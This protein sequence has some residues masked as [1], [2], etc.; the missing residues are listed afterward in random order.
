MPPPRTQIDV[1]S[2]FR[3]GAAEARVPSVQR[4]RS[5]VSGFAGPGL[6]AI[7]ERIPA[8]SSSRASGRGSVPI[9]GCRLRRLASPAPIARA[10]AAANAAAA[11]V[12]GASGLL[13]TTTGRAGS[14]FGPT[15]VPVTV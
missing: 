12:Q 14:P 11:L 10:E 4:R 5:G 9:V 2:L 1:I 15:Q 13:E 8:S 7:H 6:R 3:L